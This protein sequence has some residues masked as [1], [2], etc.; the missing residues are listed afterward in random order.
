MTPDYNIKKLD[1]DLQVPDEI[2][3]SG[4]R[5]IGKK[6]NE[7]LLPDDASTTPTP[8][9]P[10]YDRNIVEQLEAMGFTRNASIK[11]AIETGKSGGVEA[12]AEWVML[13][14]DDPSLNDPPATS[15]N[16]GAGAPAHMEGLDELIAFGFTAHQARYALNRN[17]DA[18]AAA[19][20]L[21]VHSEEVPPECA[22]S[23]SREFSDGSGKYRLVAFI[24]HMGSSPHSGHYVVHVKKDD[25]WI[26]FNDEKVAIS[27]NPPR[28]L[29]YLYLFQRYE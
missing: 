14:L 28:Q 9:L 25:R 23:A 17:P 20:W 18:N 1:L 16:P 4:L 13:R 5:G 11:A 21:F 12:A 8:T 3:L 24:S 19:E 2:D 22:T 6:E 29:A 10:D 15:S 26:L 27:Q 7:V